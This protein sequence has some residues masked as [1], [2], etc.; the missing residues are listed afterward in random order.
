MKVS[1]KIVTAE[2]EQEITAEAG[3]NLRQVL[4]KNDVPLYGSLS[5]HA[6][7]GGRGLCATCGVYLLSNDLPPIH[8]HDRLAHKFGY[9][10]LT[11]QLK[12]TEDLTI[13]IPE[14]KVMWGQLLP[15]M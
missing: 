14:N 1:I 10:R 6:N 13:Q 12:V 8:W 9:P 4:L 2:D 15:K 7:C 3:E 11:C 5:K